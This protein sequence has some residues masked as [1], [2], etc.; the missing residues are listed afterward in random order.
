MVHIV[1]DMG[2]AVV[3]MGAHVNDKPGRARQ[4]WVP[5]THVV[6]R[7]IFLSGKELNT[8]GPVLKGRSIE[9]RG[10]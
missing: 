1:I 9:F 8:E 7:C 10:A 5:L 6:G 2:A 4:P 3:D